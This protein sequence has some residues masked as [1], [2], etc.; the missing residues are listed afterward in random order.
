MRAFEYFKALFRSKAAVATTAIFSIGYYLLIEYV[1]NLN[2]TNGFVFVTTPQVLIYLLAFTSAILLTISIHSIRLSFSK[3]E[4]ELDGVASVV[5]SLF[6]GIIAGCNCAVPILA[7]IMYLFALDAA[8]VSTV[9]SFISSY[10]LEL[11]SLLI[12]LNLLISY[13]HLSTLS[14]TCTIKK[15]RL[16]RLKK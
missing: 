14:R 4:T 3:L 1:I 7:S 5:T 8:T 12:V 11:F 2:A 9:L 6:G 10:Q 13:H 15:G 16:V